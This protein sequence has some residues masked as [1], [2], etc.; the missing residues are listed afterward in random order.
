MN[1]GTGA[2]SKIERKKKNFWD[3]MSRSEILL[4]IQ[5]YASER[6][7][8][9]RK[10]YSTDIEKRDVVSYTVRRERI[11]C[12]ENFRHECTERNLGVEKKT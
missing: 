7:V 3:Q 12:N 5:W 8:K 11:T 9:S 4:K 1:R 2:E 6:L 10:N